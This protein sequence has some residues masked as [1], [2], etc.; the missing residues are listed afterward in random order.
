VND[1]PV[2]LLTGNHGWCPVF[3]KR[4]R[5]RGVI[6]R[7][8]ESPCEMANKPIRAA[9]RLHW[10]LRHGDEG[11]RLFAPR[12]RLVRQAMSCRGDH[13]HT[14]DAGRF[15]GEEVLPDLVAPRE[16]GPVPTYLLVTWSQPV[17]QLSSKGTV[18]S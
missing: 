8:E 5:D 6:I 13:F 3:Y 14:G 4:G 17:S 9:P 2:Y 18:R 1:A 11:V 16:R 12:R 15:V 10:G 7:S